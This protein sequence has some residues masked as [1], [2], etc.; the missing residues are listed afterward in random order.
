MDTFPL[1]ANYL[2]SQSRSM[3]IGCRQHEQHTGKPTSQAWKQRWM[4]VCL[5]RLLG[6]WTHSFSSPLHTQHEGFVYTARGKSLQTLAANQHHNHLPQQTL[7]SEPQRQD[8]R[9]GKEYTAILHKH[10]NCHA[11]TLQT[12]LINEQIRWNESD[13]STVPQPGVLKKT[14]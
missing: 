6:G 9:E 11:G 4:F 12:K 5:L 2:L 13:F 10:I 7:I 14:Q 8:K 1:W 3:W